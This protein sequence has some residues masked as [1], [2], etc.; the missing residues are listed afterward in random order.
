MPRFRVHVTYSDLSTEKID[1]I[2]DFAAAARELVTK[3]LRAAGEQGFKIGKVKL[4]RSDA[5]CCACV[6]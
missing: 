4:I 5:E 1:K 2:T 3:Q 6:L